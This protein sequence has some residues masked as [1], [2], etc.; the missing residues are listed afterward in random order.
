MFDF[1]QVT[2]FR[3]DFGN[4][5]KNYEKHDVSLGEAE[6]IFF[7]A[8]L[9]IVGDASHSL[10]E[11]RFHA[12]GKTDEGRR[13]HLTYTLRLNGTLVRVISARPMHR[14]ERILYDHAT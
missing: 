1:S 10:F 13:L 8:P 4:S 9:L 11:Q 14:K 6:Q 2:G 12:L 5:F 7:N 3:W